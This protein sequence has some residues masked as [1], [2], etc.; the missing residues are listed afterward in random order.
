M[1]YFSEPV[2]QLM[3]T[4]LKLGSFQAI[5]DIR[6]GFRGGALGAEAPPFLF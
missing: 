4:P 3:P 1:I 5:V 6:G 2:Q